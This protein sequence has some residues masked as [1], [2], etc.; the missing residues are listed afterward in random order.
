VEIFEQFDRRI[1]RLP[2]PHRV[3][4]GI[5]WATAVLGAVARSCQSGE[6]FARLRTGI[7]A[8]LLAQSN[9]GSQPCHFTYQLARYRGIDRHR[10][11]LYVLGVEDAS[12]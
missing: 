1:A 7:C 6:I 2:G 10:P 5:R 4:L 11:G 9:M 8:V 12:Q 3:D